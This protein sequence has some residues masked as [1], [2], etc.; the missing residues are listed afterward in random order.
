[1]NLETLAFS[2]LFVE[3]AEQGLPI[4]LRAGVGGQRSQGWRSADAI[5]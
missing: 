1:M 2:S 4:A 5:E 3:D